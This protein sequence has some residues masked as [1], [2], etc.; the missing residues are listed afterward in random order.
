MYENL[1]IFDKVVIQ[2]NTLVYVYIYILFMQVYWIWFIIVWFLEK[3][4]IN[5]NIG[6]WN[7]KKL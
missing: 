1:I 7:T 4:E 3:W 5:I 6:H 2:N